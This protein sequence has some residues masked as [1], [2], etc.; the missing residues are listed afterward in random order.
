VQ[1]VG[2]R[3]SAAREA[4]RFGISGSVRNLADG[5]VEV[6]ARGATNAVLALERWLWRGPAVARVDNVEKTDVPHDVVTTKSFEIL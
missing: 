5:R 4:L 1:G 2:F 6:V 3:W